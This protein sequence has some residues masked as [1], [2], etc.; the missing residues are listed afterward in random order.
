MAPEYS[1]SRRN[2]FIL[3]DRD[4]PKIV[5][6]AAGGINMISVLAGMKR[7]RQQWLKPLHS[8]E[9]RLEVLRVWNSPYEGDG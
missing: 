9:E 8:V 6:R 7:T 5:H 2:E 1:K 3:P 4:C